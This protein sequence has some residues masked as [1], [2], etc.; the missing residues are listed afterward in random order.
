MCIVKWKGKWMFFYKMYKCTG[1]VQNVLRNFKVD[2][3]GML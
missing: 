3:P 1:N 2:F